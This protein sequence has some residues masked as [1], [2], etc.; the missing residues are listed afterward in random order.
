MH[1]QQITLGRRLRQ[2]D[3]AGISI[4]DVAYAPGVRMPAHS[5]R[6]ANVSLVVS[7]D[8]DEWVDG[9]RYRVT[10]GSVVFKPAGTVHR[11]QYGA[12]GARAMII[13]FKSG[14]E[15]QGWF[16]QESIGQCRW[17]CSGPSIAAAVRAYCRAFVHGAGEQQSAINEVIELL[18]ASRHEWGS[19]AG[20]ALHPCVRDAKEILRQ[21]FDQP[22]AIQQI[23]ATVGVHPVY[24]ARVF[25]QQIR[26]SLTEYRRGLQVAEA[27]RRLAASHESLA[28]VAAASGF[29]DQSHMTRALRRELGTTPGRYRRF[30]RGTVT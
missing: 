30:A 18:A 10:A 28:E 11:N 19:F 4:Y 26:C 16:E 13:E 27:A 24:L 17:L 12:R 29:A 9:R 22:I 2:A 23:A 21:S 1:C 20:A 8:F 5:H 15:G 14:T 7:G 25:R 3:Y 6:S